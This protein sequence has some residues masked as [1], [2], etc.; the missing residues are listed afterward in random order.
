MNKYAFA[1]TGSRCGK[2]RSLVHWFL[3]ISILYTQA[4]IARPIVIEH[5]PND[6]KDIHCSFRRTKS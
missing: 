4:M 1:G 3:D 2:E 6:I 5:L